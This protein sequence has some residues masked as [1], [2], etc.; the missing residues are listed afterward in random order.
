VYIARE[1]MKKFRFQRGKDEKM[2]VRNVKGPIGPGWAISSIHQSPK[3]RGMVT[4][5][6][7]RRNEK[8]SR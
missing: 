1:I 4:R 6:G 7:D 5:N 2:I 8:L 3:K